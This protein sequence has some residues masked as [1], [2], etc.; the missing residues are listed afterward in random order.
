MQSMFHRPLL[1]HFI[2]GASRQPASASSGARHPASLAPRVN[3]TLFHAAW[4]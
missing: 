4:D 3:Q 2:E 1:P